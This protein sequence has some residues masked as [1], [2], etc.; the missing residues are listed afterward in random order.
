MGY[1][2]Y[3][4]DFYLH[5]GIFPWG[6][7]F[8]TRIFTYTMAFSHGIPLLKKYFILFFLH[9]GW[10]VDWMAFLKNIPSFNVGRMAFFANSCHPV[11]HHNSIPYPK[12]QVKYPQVLGKYLYFLGLHTSC[13]RFP[14][15]DSILNPA[16]QNAIL[17]E[18]CR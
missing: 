13:M 18:F 7:W 1:L 6:T 12:K 9:T 15:Q 16:P 5:N 8:T 17:M 11:C 4:Q 10:G 3:Y 2:V 14:V